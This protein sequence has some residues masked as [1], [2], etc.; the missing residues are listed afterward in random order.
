MVFDSR[1]R[2]KSGQL[3][4]DHL[5]H[6]LQM[7]EIIWK[8]SENHRRCFGVVKVYHEEDIVAEIVRSSVYQF[9]EQ[10]KEVKG[11]SD[12]EKLLHDLAELARHST[13]FACDK[14]EV[15]KTIEHCR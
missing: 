10:Y 4:E 1:R 9:I 14:H 15:V 2:V 3:G 11:V 8:T 7:A 6:G 5:K 13:S 12:N